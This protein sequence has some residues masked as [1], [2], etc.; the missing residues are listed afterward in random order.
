[1]VDDVHGVV[2]DVHGVVDDVHGVAI[3]NRSDL[4]ETHHDT[5]GTRVYATYGRLKGVIKHS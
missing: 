4:S 1:M 5:R 2:D 3:L